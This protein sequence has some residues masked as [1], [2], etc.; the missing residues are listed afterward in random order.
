[1]KCP[2][3]A[4]TSLSSKKKRFLSP[5]DDGWFS[6]EFIERDGALYRC[7]IC[8]KEKSGGWRDRQCMRTHQKFSVTHN[9]LINQAKQEKLK[10]VS[11]E[12]TPL[13]LYY[14]SE[15]PDEPIQN[16]IPVYYEFPTLENTSSDVVDELLT[17]EDELGQYELGSRAR[18]APS[19]AIYVIYFHHLLSK[20]VC[21]DKRVKF[22]LLPNSVKCGMLLE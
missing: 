3:S 17:S 13:V 7:L 8:P 20:H 14:P 21:S 19:V 12:E 11:S 2:K 18:G 15:S 5:G 22:K 6:Q 9:R 1:M 16:A 4:T 10:G